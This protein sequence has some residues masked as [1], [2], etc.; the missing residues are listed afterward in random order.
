[1]IQE[2]SKLFSWVANNLAI[3]HLLGRDKAKRNNNK[4]RGK[5]KKNKL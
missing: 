4:W 3:C 5:K 2:M 1:M